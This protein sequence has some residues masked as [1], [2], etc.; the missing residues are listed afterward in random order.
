LTPLTVSPSIVIPACDL[1]WSAVRASGPGGQ[2]VNKVSSKVE[3]RF[4]LARTTALAE[5]TK[6]RLRAMAAGR[7]DA[8]GRI[9][10][11]S[12][13]TRDQPKNLEDARARLA[14]LVL[15]ASHRPKRR[16]PTARPRSA[17]RKRLEAKKR[18]GARKRDRKVRDD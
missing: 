1:E 5:D 16:R 15:L 7:L 11:V 9:V 6:A 8:E 4:D 2:N 12:Q 17:D 13:A 3:L 18:E 10:V 14:A